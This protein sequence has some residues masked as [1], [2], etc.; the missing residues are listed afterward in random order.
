MNVCHSEEWNNLLRKNVIW[1][2]PI[3]KV[4]G[5]C[6]KVPR[7]SAFLG[8]ANI[9]YSYS[10]VI[11]YGTGWPDWFLPLLEEVND[12]SGLKYNGCLLN[13]YR[14]GNDRMGW[15]A[16]NESELD[17]SKA[18]SSLSLG[19]TREFVLK[20]QKKKITEVLS[21]NNGDLLIMHPNCQ[22]E[23]IHSI[24]TRK[25]IYSERLNLTFRCYK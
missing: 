25:R 12:V 16:D 19:A 6:H 14:D 24:P 17:H 23:W 2:Q 13:F 11:H 20:H 8:E 22:R 4:F 5:K 9:R 1:E 10:G 15:H 7:M 18:I 3:V 21:L